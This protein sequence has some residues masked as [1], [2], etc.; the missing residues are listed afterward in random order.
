MKDSLTIL[1]QFLNNNDIDITISDYLK[2]ISYEKSDLQTIGN[3]LINNI[4][5]DAY[6]AFS[7]EVK[8]ISLLITQETGV[9]LGRKQKNI[10]H[11]MLHYEE[12][13]GLKLLHNFIGKK[14][15][16]KTL[17]LDCRNTNQ[18]NIQGA[19]EQ[20]IKNLKKA[21]I[22]K[23]NK[24]IFDYLNFLYS[25]LLSHN[26]LKYKRVLDIFKE[27]KSFLQK[28]YDQ[29]IVDNFESKCKKY[30]TNLVHEESTK[31]FNNLYI[32]ELIEKSESKYDII[33][34]NIN[35][36]LFNKFSSKEYFYSYLFETI[37]HSYEKLGNHRSLIL[38][39]ENIIS[40]GLNIKWELYSYLTI[41]S[42]IFKDELETRN[43]YKPENIC[44]DYLEHRY[45]IKKSDIVKKSLGDYYKNKI[46]VKEFNHLNNVNI[47]KNE[48]DYFKKIRLGFQYID[49]LVLNRE[50]SFNNSSEIDFIGNQNELLL[51]LF[52][53]KFDDRKIP[54]PVCSTLKISGNS[55]PEIG[56]KSWECKNNL[57][58]ERSKTN[59]G[60][61]YSIKSNEMQ[62]GLNNNVPENV[63]SKELTSKWRKDVVNETSY[64]TLFEMI[65]RYYSYH[66]SNVLLLNFKKQNCIIP[67]ELFLS[68]IISFN[69][70]FRFCKKGL[71][72]TKLF[73]NFESNV[74]IKKFIYCSKNVTIQKEKIQL[75]LSVKYQIINEDCLI[76]LNNIP[77]NSIQHMVTSPPYY[78][79]REYSQW[80]NLYNY[81]HEMYNICKASFDAISPGGVFLYNIGD[82]YDNPNIVVKSNMGK[83]K[84]ALG[85]YLIYLFK[86]AGFELLDNIVW[87]KGETQS[88]RH[89]N[90]GNFTPYYQKP[91]NTY[92]HMFIFKKPGKLILSDNPIIDKN[93]IRFPPVIKI[94]SKGENI[95]GHT[96]PFPYTLPNLS[97]LSF[98]KP[99][100]IVFDPFLGS[101]TTVYV[102]VNNKRIGVGTEL[103]KNYFNLANSIIKKRIS[104]KKQIELIL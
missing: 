39:I 89:K 28:E 45:K 52:K 22:E 72:N 11:K 69:S 14:Y 42:E 68:R 10:I 51:I 97:I 65:I 38:K 84:I 66:N 30:S 35:Q 104:N 102:A 8:Q 3:S 90:D 5:C 4:I 40:E 80:N 1:T 88:N 75:D 34:I 53:N 71:D 9:Y 20:Y 21:I 67:Q 100:D 81:L 46:S 92:E 96:A 29:D 76:F 64:K 43:Y 48:L 103:D 31:I 63:I 19:K 62:D 15:E 13:N 33:A 18:Q 79:A 26:E 99:N 77:K 23:N 36:K 60:K 32:R 82:I 17:I 73:N 2:G 83:K 37:T 58:Y 16:I 7:Q 95:Y 101:G 57:C 86:T 24:R 25:R 85:A 54:C 12:F 56:I 70:L 59:R 55:Y 78:N 61:R 91:A 41:Y 93:V 50:K 94:N 27:N 6:N 44:G 98:T 47:D 87:D 74:F 49:C